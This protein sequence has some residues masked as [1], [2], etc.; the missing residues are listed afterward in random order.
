M[1]ASLWSGFKTVP[2][3]TGLVLPDKPQNRRTAK[4]TKYHEGSS[5]MGFLRALFV[6][7]VV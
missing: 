1:L 7:F 4:G 3:W 6:T 2:Q 5:L